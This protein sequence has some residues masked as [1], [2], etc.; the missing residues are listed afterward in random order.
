MLTNLRNVRA[1][2]LIY[3]AYYAPRGRQRMFALGSQLSERYLKPDD[4]LIGI[5]G[6][7]G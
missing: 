7:E 6:S 2:T 1:E 3:S 4:L 5:I